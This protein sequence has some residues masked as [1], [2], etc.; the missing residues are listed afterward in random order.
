MPLVVQALFP[1]RDDLT[2]H[3]AAVV[4]DELWL[5]VEAHD[6]PKD[7]PDVLAIIHVAR[8]RTT[9]EPVKR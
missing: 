4:G 5:N 3:G 1:D 6:I 2:V 7:E 8:R 9:F